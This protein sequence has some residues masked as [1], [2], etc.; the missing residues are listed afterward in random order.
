MDQVPP[1]WIKSS[2]RCIATKAKEYWSMTISGSKQV[3]ATH[4]PPSLGSAKTRYRCAIH[5]LNPSSI[6]ARSHTFH[7]C[8]QCHTHSRGSEQA[9]FRFVIYCQTP[10]GSTARSSREFRLCTQSISLCATDKLVLTN[11]LHSFLSK[12]KQLCASVSHGI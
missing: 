6:T 5:G 11:L 10:S 3:N 9:R 4:V 8:M 1:R 7:L 2:T 12:I